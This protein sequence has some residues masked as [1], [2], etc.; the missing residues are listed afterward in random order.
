MAAIYEETLNVIN[1]STRIITTLGCGF[2]FGKDVEAEIQKHKI[3]SLDHVANV[4][5]KRM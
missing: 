1:H 5:E 3:T 4:W 2:S